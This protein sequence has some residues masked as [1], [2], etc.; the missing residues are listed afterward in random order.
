MNLFR[1]FDGLL[2]SSGKFQMP[3][4]VLVRRVSQVLM[5]PPKLVMCLGTFSGFQWLARSRCRKGL[6]ESISPSVG[7]DHRCAELLLIKV[8]YSPREIHFFSAI[9]RGG[10]NSMNSLDL[11][12]MVGKKDKHIFPKWWLNMVMNPMESVKNHQLNEQRYFWCPPSRIL[13]ANEGLGWNLP[14]KKVKR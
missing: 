10:Q 9:C 7:S 5:Y 12:K 11:L 1:S 6:P 2:S 8:K 3:G 4:Q 14:L 13:V